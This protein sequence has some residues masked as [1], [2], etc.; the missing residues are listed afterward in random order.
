MGHFCF[1]VVKEIFPHRDFGFRLGFDL[2]DT[3]IG[4]RSDSAELFDVFCDLR[5]VGS[6][7]IPYEFTDHRLTLVVSGSQ[8]EAGLYFDNRDFEKI[9]SFASLDQYS[10][11]GMAEKVVLLLA[12]VSPPRIFYLHAGAVSFDGVGI[13]ILGDSFS[14]KT[15][16][17]HEF[18]NAGADYFSDDCVPVSNSGL[19]HPFAI[20]M[21]VRVGNKRMNVVPEKPATGPHPAHLLLFTKFRAGAKWV[22]ERLSEGDAAFRIIQN[23]FYRSPVRESPLDYLS[24]ASRLGRS[25][26]SF[27]SER[28]ESAEIVEWILSGGFKVTSSSFDR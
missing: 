18:V 15:T 26:V 21:S 1:F 28:A 23:V 8:S 4:I 17:V 7:M 6:A 16:L 25:S 12:A 3:R 20:P 19:I 27:A 11:A 9:H 14:G 10:V 2:F 24:F 13:L 5:P 22:P